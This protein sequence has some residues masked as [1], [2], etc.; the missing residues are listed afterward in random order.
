M[1]SCTQNRIAGTFGSIAVSAHDQTVLIDTTARNYDTSGHLH[2]DHSFLRLSINDAYRLHNLLGHAIV[3]AEE[4][5]ISVKDLA[6]EQQ[7]VHIKNDRS[8]KFVHI[9][10]TAYFQYYGATTT[11]FRLL[12][13]I[14]ISC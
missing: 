13:A 14:S 8:G 4:H 11:R 3:A 1:S 2:V 9:P 6:A 7:A 12:Q 10:T 5:R